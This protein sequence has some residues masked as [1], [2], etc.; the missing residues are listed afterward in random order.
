MG[1]ARKP[2][3]LNTQALWNYALRLLGQ[4]AHSANEI[5]A[6]LLR[7][8]ELPRDVDETM[9]KLREYG[10]A[11]DQKFSEAFAAA[12]LQNEGFG[13]LRVLRELQTKKVASNIASNAV[14]KTF[15]GTDEG[16]LI[17]R[18]LERRY[19][20]KNLKEHLKEQKNLAS[21]Y[22]RLRTAGFTSAGSLKVL[23]RFTRLDAD[24]EEPPES[25]I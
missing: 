14:E 12:R 9:V 1:R 7:R 10:L 15:V 23:K 11:D 13:R 6:K 20:G 22:R 21:A 5:R 8:A 25:D 17:E 3:K 16:E 18:F 2:K 4:R 19:R 24:W